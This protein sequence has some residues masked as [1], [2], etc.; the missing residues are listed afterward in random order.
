[1]LIGSILSNIYRDIDL[2]FFIPRNVTK[3]PVKSTALR[4]M[5]IGIT[6]LIINVPFFFFEITVAGYLSWALKAT[7]VG[8]YAVVV[9]L[10][11]SLI[12][13]RASLKATF[14]RFMGMVK[15]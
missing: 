12:F 6:V 5:R 8:I 1:V 14:V 4:I 2:L 10:I 11:M 9:I 7:Y 15:R 13:D 3:L